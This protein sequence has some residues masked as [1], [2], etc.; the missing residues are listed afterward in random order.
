CQT[1]WKEVEVAVLNNPRKR[2]NS[3]INE[4]TKRHVGET[5]WRETQS[6]KL[7]QVLCVI[8]DPVALVSSNQ[9]KATFDVVS[10]VIVLCSFLS[11]DLIIVQEMEDRV[12]ESNYML[13]EKS[14][15]VH[16]CNSTTTSMTASTTTGIR[17]WWIISTPTDGLH[18]SYIQR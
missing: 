14:E 3:G 4:I 17:Q 9:E 7:K 6:V 11:A 8:T 12:K 10:L 1:P 5:L 18:L 2:N 15:N 16:T 13:Q